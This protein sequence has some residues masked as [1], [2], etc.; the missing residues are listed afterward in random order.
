VVFIG[1][2]GDS[3]KKKKEGEGAGSGAPRGGEREGGSDPTSGQR[4]DDS[5]SEPTG[6]GVLRTSGLLQCGRWS[7]E[8]ESA[9]KFKRFNSLQNLSKLD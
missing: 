1:A 9:S 7:N 2:E 6:A 4:L 8:F 3:T 5:G